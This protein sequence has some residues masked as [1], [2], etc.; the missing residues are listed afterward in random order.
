MAD[1]IPPCTLT[2][3]GILGPMADSQD[4]GTGLAR[5][6]APALSQNQAPQV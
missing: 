4:P 5:Q 1:R 6:Q 2:G 3:T